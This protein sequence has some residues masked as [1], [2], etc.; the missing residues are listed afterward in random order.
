MAKN[1]PLK[2]AVGLM[3]WVLPIL[4]PRGTFPPTSNRVWK[5]A[6]HSDARP[7]YQVA[8]DFVPFPN[9]QIFCVLYHQ[10]HR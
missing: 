7:P 3:Q 2:D 4:K 9:V 6:D 1:I 10:I 8:F 5:R